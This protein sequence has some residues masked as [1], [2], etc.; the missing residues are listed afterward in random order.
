M[1][2]YF[3]LESI[4]K[5]LI[6]TLQRKKM[7]W[8]THTFILDTVSIVLII[9]N[10]QKSLSTHMLDPRLKELLGTPFLPLWSE[11]LGDFHEVNLLKILVVGGRT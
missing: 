1:Y 3:M 6:Y 4:Q 11:R 8:R 7:L 5:L 9:L 2:N 10:E